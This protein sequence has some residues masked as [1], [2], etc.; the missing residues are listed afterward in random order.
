MGASSKA[1]R[2][3]KLQFTRLYFP[4]TDQYLLILTS[5][6]GALVPLFTEL[7]FP[8][9]LVSQT[10]SRLTQWNFLPLHYWAKEGECEAVAEDD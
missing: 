7:D 2:S 8:A 4:L 3:T 5:S 6:W 10:E 9:N 1:C